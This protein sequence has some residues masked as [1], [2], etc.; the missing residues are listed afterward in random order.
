M[1]LLYW[2][3]LKVVFLPNLKDDFKKMF[4][5]KYLIS[6]QFKLYFKTTYNLYCYN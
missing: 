2:T 3:S 6:N 1:Y 4:Y 5:Y